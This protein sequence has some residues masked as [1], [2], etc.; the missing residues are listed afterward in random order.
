MA[1]NKN[2]DV[3][4]NNSNDNEQ[5]SLKQRNVIVPPVYK[6]DNRLK[7]YKDSVPNPNILFYTA[8]TGIRVDTVQFYKMLVRK[9][10]QFRTVVN[11][12]KL[13]AIS[14]DWEI[15]A[16]DYSDGTSD[17]PRVDS[18]AGPR[19]DSGAGPRRNYMNSSNAH[20][21]NHLVD[22]DITVWVRNMFRN[23]IKSFRKRLI[24]MMDAIVTGYTVH[25][26]ITEL[27]ANGNEVI[28]DLLYRNPERFEFGSDG[29]LYLL[30]S[31]GV[32]RKMLPNEHFMIHTNDATAENP[33]GESVLGEASFWLYY[34]KNGNWKDWAQFNERFGQGILKGEYE[35]GNIQ[36][37]RET[38]EALKLLRSNGYA[39]FEKGSNIEIL[40]ASRNS[41]DYKEM[42][43]SI[44]KAISRMVI[45][46]ELTT[47][48]GSGSGSYALG[49]VHEGTFT[50]IV[51]SDRYNLEDTI[52]EMIRNICLRNF[53]SLTRFPKFRFVSHSGTRSEDQ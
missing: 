24:E 21:D 3:D 53:K 49:K 5:N 42:L 23:H 11:V 46:Q 43:N 22:H 1:K 27:D 13:A 45:G 26:I 40:E 4:K 28:T 7:Y 48:A 14:S 17:R 10:S 29:S 31:L 6:E 2:M 19:V 51:M 47:S 35:R 37:M 30:G 36:A 32:D 41:I 8:N 50:N 18:G 39:V 16:D 38:F 25:E 9:D 44:D 33:Y 34:L 15:V 12:R 20:Y 52:N